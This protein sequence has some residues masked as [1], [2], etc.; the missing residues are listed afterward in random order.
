MTFSIMLSQMA[1][2]MGRSIGIFFLTLIFSMPLGLLVSFGRMSKIKPVKYFTKFYISVLRG[3]PLMLQLMVVYFFPYYLF[4]WSIGNW[5]Y[6]AIIVGF[7]I[8]Y[9][10]YFA[11]IY[12]SGIQSIPKGQYEAGQ[13]LGMSRPQ[14]FTKVI[15]MQVAR[16][17]LPPMSNEIITLVKDTSLA[18]VIVVQDILYLASERY[19][20]VGIIWPLFYTGVFY[21]LFVGILTLLFNYLEKKMSYYRI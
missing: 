9:S 20:A 19:A 10:A 17:I 21:L 7:V 3:T 5:R 12:R 6:P 1:I 4:G 11:E 2:G 8:N 14:I 15:L 18:R 16:R 13:V